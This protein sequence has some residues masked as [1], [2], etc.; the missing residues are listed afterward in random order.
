MCYAAMT[1]CRQTTPDSPLFLIGSYRGISCCPS[2]RRV[3]TATSPVCQCVHL[4][5]PTPLEQM[6]GK[7]SNLEMPVGPNFWFP[8][9]VG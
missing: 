2:P 4:Q 7:P 9:L 3:C 1:S 8:E 5:T 6:G